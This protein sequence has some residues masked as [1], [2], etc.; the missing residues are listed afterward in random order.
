[1]Q[2]ALFR[3]SARVA[4]SIYYSDNHCNTSAFTIYIYIYVCVCL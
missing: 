4:L 2:T 3:F 1:M